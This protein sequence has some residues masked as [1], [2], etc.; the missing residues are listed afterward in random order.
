MYLGMSLFLT[1]FALQVNVVGGIPLALLFAL[2]LNAFQI[3]PEE[4]ALSEKFGEEYRE[5]SRRVR[6]WI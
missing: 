5:Y 2:Y 3:L 1:G 6:R 4:R